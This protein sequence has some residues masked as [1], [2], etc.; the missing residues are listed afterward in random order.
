MRILAIV[1]WLFVGL[2]AGIYHFGPGQRQLHL[3]SIASMIHD[4]RQ[5]IADQN[6]EQAI[7]SFDAVLSALPADLRIESMQIQL[8]KAKA[9]MMAAELPA[10][11]TM[12]DTLLADVRKAPVASPKL[13][14]DTQA[15]LANAQYYM[16][17]LMRLEGAAEEDWMAEIESARQNFTQVMHEAEARGDSRLAQQ[18]SEDVESAIR[19]ARMDLGELQVLPLPCQCK[20]CC[21]G[22]GKKAGKRKSDNS[23]KGAGKVEISEGSGS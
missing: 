17:W 11:R 7:S 13:L 1:A 15:T 10:A 4:A 8:E 12:L 20:G 19:L 6:W 22:K 23:A 3:D 9:Q 5:A 16:A 2:G 18:S 21:S 14:A